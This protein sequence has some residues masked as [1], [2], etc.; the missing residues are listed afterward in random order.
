SQDRKRLA[1]KYFYDEQGSALFEQ[2]CET[3]EYY[4]TRTELAML[5][6]FDRRASAMIGEG[7]GVVEYGGGSTDKAER[8]L[9]ALS[10]P[11]EYIGI[12][13]S[14]EHLINAAKGLAGKR[15]DLSVGAV[16]A[17]FTQPLDIPEVVGEE[18]PRRLGFFPGSTIGNLDRAEARQFL[19]QA[20]ETLTPGGA[21]LVGVD[22]KKD[23]AALNA[24]YN[25]RDGVTAEFNLNI[26]R[27]M[28]R[29]LGADVDVDGF[30][31]LA[32]FNADDGRIEM[33]LK[34]NKS[35]SIGVAGREFQFE[36][37]ETIH[38]ENSYKYGLEEFRQVAKDARYDE[39]FSWTD[40]EELFS[41]HLLQSAAPAA[42]A[43][44][45]GA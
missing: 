13:I 11:Q 44:Q 7:R 16:C 34:A 42:M 39:V 40:R 19:A 36:K 30:D 9:G 3:E 15:P 2:I 27:R 35:Q 12:D 45:Q 10:A 8:L 17:D 31:H 20:R 43:P 5:D 26:L 37:G 6:D 32:F 18:P 41:L 14:K 4:V 24:A 29:E 28:K 1:P 23:E 38:T 22:L 25:D 21:L 33:H